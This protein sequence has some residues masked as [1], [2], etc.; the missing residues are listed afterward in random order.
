VLSDSISTEMD[1]SVSSGS[2]QLRTMESPRSI[3]FFQID[4]DCGSNSK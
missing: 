3:G 1:C 4:L 2:A